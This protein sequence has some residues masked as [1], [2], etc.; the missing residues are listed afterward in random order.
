MVKLVVLLLSLSIVFTIRAQ[1]I[2]NDF[3]LQKSQKQ[4]VVNKDISKKESQSFN[5][6]SHPLSIT[7]GALTLL[8]AGLYVV[9]SETLDKKPITDGFLENYSPQVP[10]QY[11]GIGVFA[12]G[13]VL[14]AI[15]STDRSVKTTKRKKGKSYNASEWELSEE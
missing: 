2:P 5:N 8:G 14:F 11:I 9:G 15:F 4:P 10:L 7:G 1:T 12:T 6:L 3:R 13:A